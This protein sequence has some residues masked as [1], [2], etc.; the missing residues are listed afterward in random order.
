MLDV[1]QRQL[2][3]EHDGKDQAQYAGE[4]WRLVGIPRAP[5]VKSRTYAPINLHGNISGLAFEE[6]K[7]N[8]GFRPGE[9]HKQD[10]AVNDMMGSKRRD[11]VIQTAMRID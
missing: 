6:I 10:F 4:R 7:R 11:A 1:R 2:K 8:N 5:S 3:F 9:I